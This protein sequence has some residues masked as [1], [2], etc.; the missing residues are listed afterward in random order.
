MLAA[1]ESLTSYDGIA[2]L[3][4]L[5]RAC[6]LPSGFV[7]PLQSNPVFCVLQAK[8]EEEALSVKQKAEE[9]IARAASEAKEKKRIKKEQ[10]K[11][12]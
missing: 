10:L 3:T 11:V 4:E 2:G 12:S 9:Q 5:K 8:A 7:W 1:L 6:K